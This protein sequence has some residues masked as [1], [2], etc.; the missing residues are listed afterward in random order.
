MSTQ[1][2]LDKDVTKL[3]NAATHFRGLI[4]SSHGAGV[5]LGAAELLNIVNTLESAAYFIR[6]RTQTLLDAEAAY[7][8]RNKTL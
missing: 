3:T 5:R 2:I 7:R 1:T 4:D 8:A 6:E